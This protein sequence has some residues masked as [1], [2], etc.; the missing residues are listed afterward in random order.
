MCSCFENISRRQF[1]ASIELEEF[2]RESKKPMAAE[3]KPISI[4]KR[5]PR[6]RK[7]LHTYRTRASRIEQLE[8]EF[9]VNEKKM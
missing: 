3:P 7:A 4:P 6:R 5:T 9:E 8:M 1:M 2:R